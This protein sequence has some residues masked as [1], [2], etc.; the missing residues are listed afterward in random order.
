MTDAIMWAQFN[1]SDRMTVKYEKER[2][3]GEPA[4]NN[5]VRSCKM[6]KLE[7]ARDGVEAILKSQVN[8]AQPS[9]LL[10]RLVADRKLRR[11][12]LRRRARLVQEVSHFGKL[13]G[14]RR[15][16]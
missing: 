7:R 11:R 8:P 14:L 15:V 10:L 12:E 13:D 1:S 4:K 3:L 5:L 9:P 2:H 16:F 6:K